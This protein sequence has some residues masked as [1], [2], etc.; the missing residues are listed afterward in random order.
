MQ[1]E[2]MGCFANCQGEATDRL[3]AWFVNH[4]FVLNKK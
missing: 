3:T 2:E 4:E 1:V